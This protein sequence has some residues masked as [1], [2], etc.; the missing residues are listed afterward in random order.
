MSKNTPNNDYDIIISGGGLVGASLACALGTQSLRIA[1]VEAVPFRSSEQPSYDDR[2]I[3]LSYGTKSI[4]D[5]LGVWALLKENATPIKN[6]HVSERGGFGVTRINHA[7]E[8][9]EALGYVATARNIGR[10]LI[11]QLSTFSSVEILSPA[12]LIDLQ[13]DAGHVRATVDS[14][15]KQNI[16]NAELMVAADGGQSAVRDLVGINVKQTDYQQS[17]IITNVSSEYFHNHVAYERFTKHGPL[18]LLPLTDDRCAL[19]WTQNKKRVSDVM[20]LSDAEFLTQLHK[21]FGNRLGHFTKV[22]ERFVYPLQLVRAEEQVRPQLALIGNAAHT[23][24]PIA[25]QGFNL[26]VR[27]IAALAEIIV[28]AKQENQP[29]GQLD[30][31]QQYAKWRQKDHKKII[32][33]TDNLVRLF[34][35]SFPPLHAARNTGLFAMDITPTAKHLLATHTMGLAGK[36][37][38]L[39][40]GISL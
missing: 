38:R 26:G 20:A 40:R 32:S 29:I 7:D 5:T 22:G 30:V 15:G 35:N 8:N 10:A 36:L 21:E 6:I 14:N 16:L 17:A 11:K 12:K 31:L 9:V 27:D 33:F 39:A 25:G 3:A 23:I 24:H 34:S 18:A 37:P 19:V 13:F 1:V 4:F 28:D 2:A